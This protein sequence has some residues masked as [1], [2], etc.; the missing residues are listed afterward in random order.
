MIKALSDILQ[1]AENWPTEAQEEL[2]QIAREIDA[3]VKGE[4][5]FA[6]EEELRAIDD[7]RRSGIA[8][9]AEVVALWKRL[10]GDDTS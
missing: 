3:A 1:T 6:S 5:Y 2:A 7:G 9:D 10:S 4:R 8:S